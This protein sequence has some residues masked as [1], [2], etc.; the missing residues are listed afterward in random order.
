M[1]EQFN[2]FFDNIGKI[3]KTNNTYKL[4]IKGYQN[5]S[6]VRDHLESY[7]LFTYK[8]VHFLTWCKILDLIKNKAH[9]TQEGLFEIVQLKAIF[10]KSL[11]PLLVKSFPKIDQNNLNFKLPE[12]EPN[13][14]LMDLHWLTGFINGDGSFAPGLKEKSLSPQ[15]RIGQDEISLV[16]LNQIKILLGMGEVYSN[17]PNL[18]T[19]VYVL[20]GLTNLNKFND[21]LS[22]ASCRFYGTKYL[23]Y[24]DW[25]KIIS[26]INEKKTF[27]SRR[28]YWNKNN[29]FRYE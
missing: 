4:V 3:N 7:P 29:S 8:L 11:N 28:L 17:G 15:V 24:N 13:L 20:S 9:L 22:S 21:L 6:K 26:I 27:K 10:P 1:L 14:S 23:D 2:S 5:C 18:K 19:Y 16:V 12:Y 25:C